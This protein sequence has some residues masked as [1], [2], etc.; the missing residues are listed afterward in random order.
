MSQIGQPDC[1][2]HKLEMDHGFHHSG[3]YSNRGNGLYCTSILHT[4]ILYIY[5]YLSTYVYQR[6]NRVYICT[7]LDPPNSCGN[8][9]SSHY[10]MTCT[11]CFWEFGGSRYISTP[12]TGWCRRILNCQRGPARAGVQVVETFGR[13]PAIFGRGAAGAGAEKYGFLPLCKPNCKDT[14]LWKTSRKGLM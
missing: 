9:F 13:F 8:V 12:E 6:Y 3:G 5:T 10:F 14:I 4:Y 2:F 7:Y 1:F 11:N